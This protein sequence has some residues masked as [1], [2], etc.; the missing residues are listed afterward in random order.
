MLMETRLLEHLAVAPRRR[1]RG[2]ARAL[3]TAVEQQ[4]RAT[5]GVEVWFGFVDDHE[6]DALGMYRHLGFEIAASTAELPGAANLIRRAR[7]SRT[8]RGSTRSSDLRTRGVVMTE[9][10]T[11]RHGDRISLG[12]LWTDDPRRGVLRTLCVD[13]FTGAGDLGARAVCTVIRCHDTGTGQV[14]EPGRVVSIN[15]DSLHTTAGGRGYR[16]AAVD[17]PRPS[18]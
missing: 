2:Y 10:I 16:L 14:T 18:R 8:A 9:N 1:G 5:D 13:G 3:L 15:I 11:N 6:R 12:Q 17:D 7:I 4:H